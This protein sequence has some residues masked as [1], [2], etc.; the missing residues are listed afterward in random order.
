MPLQAS[1]SLLIDLPVEQVWS[2]LRDLTLAPHYVPDLTGCQLHPGP[3]E[4]LGASRRVFQKNGQWLDETVS[5]WH[6]GEGF[7]IRL[8]RGGKGAPVPFREAWFR[9]AI[10]SAGERTAFTASLSYR[11]R[12]GRLVEWLLAK[13]FAKAVKQ[14]AEN[15]KTFYESGQTQNRDFAG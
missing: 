8:H 2:K 12:G 7:L 6:E 3:Q 14:I 1:H 10:A 15:L 11:L 5:E 4:G 13:A 9:Y